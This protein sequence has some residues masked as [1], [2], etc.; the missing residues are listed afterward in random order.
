MSK[1]AKD[2]TGITNI[3]KIAKG[4]GLSSPDKP[5]APPTPEKIRKARATEDA[6]VDSRVSSLRAA[7]RSGRRSLLSGPATGRRQT[8][9]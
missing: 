4:V 6:N 9:G 1:K 5:K 7:S 3:K 2:L 8:L